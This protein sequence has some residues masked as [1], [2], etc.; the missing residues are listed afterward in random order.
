MKSIK[1]ISNCFMLLVV[2]LLFS[3]CKGSSE[4]SKISPMSNENI[5]EIRNQIKESIGSRYIVND[6][7]YQ[8]IDL[9]TKKQPFGPYYFKISTS[10]KVFVED[11]KPRE[12]RI[13]NIGDGIVRLFQ[14]F[15]SNAFSLQYFDVWNDRTSEIFSPYTIYTDYIDIES[16]EHL[17]AYFDFPRSSKKNTLLIKDIF[18]EQGFSMEIDRGFIS[19]TCNKLI[20]LNANEIYIDYDVFADEYSNEYLREDKFVDYKNIREIVKFR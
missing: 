18:D 6:P 11:I 10:K 7:L 14:A 19:P 16:K 4:L 13:D 20:I 1:L 9:S 2:L 5:E 8:I 17:V 12:P 3:I 15:G